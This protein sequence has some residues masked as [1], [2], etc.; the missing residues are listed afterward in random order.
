MAPHCSAAKVRSFPHRGNIVLTQSQ[1]ER[2]WEDGYLKLERLLEPEEVEGLRE[3]LED[4]LHGRVEW[5]RRCFQTLD[6]ARYRASSGGPMPEGIQL[7]AGQD[8][9]FRVV[10]EHPRLAEVMRDLMGAAVMRYTDQVILKTPGISPETHFHQDGFY[11]R[12]TPE[13]TIN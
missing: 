2:F 3:R 5:P 7:P 10:A 4:V 1:I 13:K 12:S 8:E 11:W 9:R 6:P